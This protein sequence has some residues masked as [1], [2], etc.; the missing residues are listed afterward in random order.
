MLKSHY[1]ETL[2][3][4]LALVMG[5]LMAIAVILL[6]GIPFNISTVFKI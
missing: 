3:L 2:L 4:V 1:G 6:D 5:L